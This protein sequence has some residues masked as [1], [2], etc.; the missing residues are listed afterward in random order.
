MACKTAG[1]KVYKATKKYEFSQTCNN[2]GEMA[3][4][5]KKIRKMTKSNLYTGTGDMGTTSLVGGERVK[6]NS[7]RL[8]AYG[9]VD[10]LSSML[11][12]VASDPKCE[13]EVRGQIREVQ[14]ELFNIGSYLATAPAPGTE[15]R[16]ASVTVERIQQL[17]GWIDALDEQTPKIRAFVLPGGCDTA[18]RAHVARVVCRRAERRILDLSEESYVDPA[19]V[20]YINRLSDWLFIVARYFNFMQGEE[21]IIWRKD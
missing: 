18:S 10:E 20:R 4:Q 16:C 11:G 21:E 12:L 13:E 3:L 15:P 14:N 5:R 8:E 7:V 6:K 2:I 1:R 9:T 19:V 17:E